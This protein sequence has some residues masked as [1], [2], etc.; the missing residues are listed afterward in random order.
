MY[1][2]EYKTKENENKTKDKIEPQHVHNQ[3]LDK[4]VNLTLVQDTVLVLINQ[5][6]EETFQEVNNLII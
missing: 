3:M 2:N 1:D 6:K 5:G 4:E